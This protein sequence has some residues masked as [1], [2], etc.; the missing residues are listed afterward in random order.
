MSK[1]H[2]RAAPKWASALGACL[3]EKL[4]NFR[5][6]LHCRA[7]CIAAGALC[8]NVLESKKAVDWNPLKAFESLF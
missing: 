1:L 4:D 6:E 3:V 2:S 8:E 5:F 7:P